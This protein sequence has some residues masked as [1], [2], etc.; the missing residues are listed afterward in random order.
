MRLE[1][2]SVRQRPWE[3]ATGV[4]EP[5]GI[6]V[7]HAVRMICWLR[8]EYAHDD[9]EYTHD[10]GLHLSEDLRERASAFMEKLEPVFHGR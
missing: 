5:N 9:Q 3:L 1:T 6:V 10:R 4:L 2:L 7:P 8:S